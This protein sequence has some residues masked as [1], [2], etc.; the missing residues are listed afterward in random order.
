MGEVLL[1]IVPLA[2]RENRVEVW[3]QP[4]GA[5]ELT[6]GTSEPFAVRGVSP[7]HEEPQAHHVLYEVRG[8]QRRSEFVPDFPG[9]SHKRFVLRDACPL[10]GEKIEPDVVRVEGEQTAH[11]SQRPE[12]VI[13]HGA[14]RDLEER[15]LRKGEP[16]QDVELVGRSDAQSLLEE[17]GE[18]RHLDLMLDGSTLDRLENADPDL[19]RGAEVRWVSPNL[20]RQRVTQRFDD[21]RSMSR[22]IRLGKQEQE[23]GAPLVVGR[24]DGVEP[25][26]IRTRPDPCRGVDETGKLARHDWRDRLMVERLAQLEPGDEVSHR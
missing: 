25:E 19:M 18:G 3:L 6:E 4:G 9:P 14:G 23:T 20:G 12:S 1:P 5:R 2:S 24:T 10:R 26:H 7:L 11:L 15:L 21:R 17:P 16:V 13:E 8:D 22:Q